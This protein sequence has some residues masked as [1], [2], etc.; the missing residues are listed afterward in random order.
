M[1]FIS[2]PKVDQIAFEFVPNRITAWFVRAEI[3]SLRTEEH[4]SQL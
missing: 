2:C 3:I 1:V 4:V